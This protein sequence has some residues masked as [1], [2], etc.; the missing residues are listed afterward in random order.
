[1]S[2]KLFGILIIP[3]LVIAIGA[4]LGLIPYKRTS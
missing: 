3:T 2:A 4:L 1:M